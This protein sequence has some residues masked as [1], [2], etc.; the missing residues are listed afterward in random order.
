MDLFRERQQN[1]GAAQEPALSWIKNMNNKNYSE[2]NAMWILPA[3]QYRSRSEYFFARWCDK[4]HIPFTYEPECFEMS[5]LEGSVRYI[6]DFYLTDS[7][8]FVEVKPAIFKGELWKFTRFLET[9]PSVTKLCKDDDDDPNHEQWDR[10]ELALG[11]VVEIHNQEP[12]AVELYDDCG[13]DDNWRNW[14]P[15]SNGFWVCSECGR[16]YIIPVGG[17]SCHHCKYYPGGG[18]GDPYPSSFYPDLLAKSII[19]HRADWKAKAAKAYKDAQAYAE[20]RKDDPF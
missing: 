1:H 10:D 18:G 8:I 19:Q 20:R 17:Y 15:E 3:G 5:G 9:I 13:M 14:K 2:M 6:P 7:N 11:W 4:W 12:V 16:P